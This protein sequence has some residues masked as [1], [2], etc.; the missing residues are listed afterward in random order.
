MALILL[1]EDNPQNM[2]LATLVLHSDGH[3]VLQA[4]DAEHGIQ[5]AGSARPA[6]VLMDVNLPGLDGLE[7]TRRLKADPATAMIPVYALTAHAMPDDA[8]R[9]MAAG[10][11]GYLSKPFHHQE[12]RRLVKQALAGRTISPTP[13]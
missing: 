8:A 10:C 2:K 6:L 12:L 3:I 9:M 13:P 4:T 5:L 11:D 1:V 7:A